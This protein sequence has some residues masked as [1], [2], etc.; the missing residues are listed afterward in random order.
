MLSPS[1]WASCVLCFCARGVP[2]DSKRQDLFRI[3]QNGH[4]PVFPMCVKNTQKEATWPCLTMGEKCHFHALVNLAM[5]CTQRRDA[6]SCL[7]QQSHTTMSGTPTSARSNM[8]RGSSLICHTTSHIGVPIFAG[9]HHL[10]R[11]Y[12]TISNMTLSPCSHAP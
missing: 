4:N 3:T 1:T 10:A 5:V 11:E 6:L 8:T 9:P 12:P 2:K 7:A